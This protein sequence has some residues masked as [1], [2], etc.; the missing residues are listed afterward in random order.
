MRR[1]FTLHIIWLI[2]FLVVFLAIT[3]ENVQPLKQFMM[4]YSSYIFFIESRY[5]YSFKRNLF[6]RED[7]AFLFVV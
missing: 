3:S 2:N 7:A 4:K 1:Q 6:I 5:E